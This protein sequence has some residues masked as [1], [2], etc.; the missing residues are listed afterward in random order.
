ML[1]LVWLW[2]L[3]RLILSIVSQKHSVKW[4]Q[5]NLSCK[6]ISKLFRIKKY[7]STIELVFCFFKSQFLDWLQIQIFSASRTIL[8]LSDLD[9]GKKLVTVLNTWYPDDGTLYTPD[10]QRCEQVAIGVKHIVEVFISYS[11]ATKPCSFK[12]GS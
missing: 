7:I 6:Y 9:M 10:F 11:T 12:I 4:C 1:W 2:R 3:F 8:F 5:L